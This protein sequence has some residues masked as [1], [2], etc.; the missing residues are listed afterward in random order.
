MLQTVV[1][2]P[3]FFFGTLMDLDVLEIVSGQSRAQLTCAPASAEGVVQRNVIGQDF[4][5]LVDAPGAHM[6]GRIVYGLTE[7]ARDRI[8]FY[9]GEEYRV[10]DITVRTADGGKV[11]CH[12]FADNAVYEISD[13]P[14]D[15]DAWQR[16]QK[17]EFLSRARRFMAL[18]GT[19]SA[20]A[21]DAY[22]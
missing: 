8:L 15:F 9:E 16:T 18:Y 5:V 1:Q 21:A 13:V 3:M 6:T 12:Y 7:T 10:C 14:W 2:T 22:W 11:A 17:T 20:A 19:M 4:P